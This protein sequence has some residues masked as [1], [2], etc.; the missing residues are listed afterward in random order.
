MGFVS[1]IPKGSASTTKPMTWVIAFNP[2]SQGN[3]ATSTVDV[4]VTTGATA[5]ATK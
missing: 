3:A 4:N 5:L 1:Y 2:D